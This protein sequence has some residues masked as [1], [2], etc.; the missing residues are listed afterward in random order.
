MFGGQSNEENQMQKIHHT[1]R[2]KILKTTKS[3][4][5]PENPFAPS[6]Q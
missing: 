3:I 5:V 2:R 1:I 6:R 4:V